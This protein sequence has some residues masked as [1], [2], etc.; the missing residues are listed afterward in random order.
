MRTHSRRRFV[1]SVVVVGLAGFVPLGC[2]EPAPPPVTQEGLQEAKKERETIIQKEYG[3]HPTAP[4][5]R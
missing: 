1:A 5:K 4:K 2:T 3:S